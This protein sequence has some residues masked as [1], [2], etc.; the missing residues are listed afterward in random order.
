[1]EH[2]VTYLG[3]IP[4]MPLIG[5]VVIGLM[6]LATCKGN[7]LPEKLYGILACVG[8]VLSF[9]LAVKVFFSLKGMPEEARYLTHKA[10]TWFHVGEMDISMGF[11]ADPLSSLM[12]LFVTFIGT[13]IHVYSIGYMSEDKNYGKFFAYLNLFLGSMLILVLGDGPVVMF[14]GWEGVGL[15]SYLLISFW[16]EDTDNVLAGNKAFIVNRIGDLGFVLGMGFL[17]WAIGAGGFDYLSLR[18]NAHNLTPAIG[19]AVCLLLFVGATGKSAQI[20]LYVWLPDAMAGPTPVSALIHAATMVTAGVYMVARFSFIYAHVPV[21][22][23][24]VAWVGILTALLAAIFGM[25]QEDIK[26]ILA[27]STVSQLGYMFAAVGVA[28]YSAGIFHVFTHAFF[29]ALLFLGSGSVIIALHH[30]QNIW[31]M[32]GLREKMPITYKT[33]FIGAL[34]LAGA[35]LF[36]GFFS[37][38]EILFS[39]LATGHTGIWAVGVLVA[40]MTAYYTFRMI[41]VVF[42][43]E[44]RDKHA[45]DHAKEPSS[46]MTVPLIILAIGAVFA[47]FL[48]VPGS[49][50]VS[51]WLSPSLVEH[52]PHVSTWYTV[53]AMV[54]SIIAFIIGITIAYR[55]F[56]KGKGAEEPV[57]TGFAKFG[58]NLFYVDQLYHAVFV[59]PYK[60]IGAVIWKF[61]DPNV[62]DLHVKLS[63]LLYRRLSEAFKVFQVG[64]VRIY[65]IYMVIGLSVM[66]LLISQSMN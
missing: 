53:F 45:F 14:V 24:I 10:F 35:P 55:K 30:E 57:Y 22:G 27:Y 47:G 49:L 63:T 7:R 36:S 21:A 18:E 8:P 54:T 61:F 1:M 50:K 60:A 2:T 44:A 16:S 29:K 56:G 51:H 52:H 20:P 62:A 37:K 4:L 65:A 43:G 39:A 13:L 5:A 41:F 34:A 42:H 17:F 32:G 59:R 12:L 23:S 28:A 33:M 9:L 25:F 31:K 19:L 6:H 66:S 64:Y 11:L 58:Y 26:K 48:N 40:G 3:L 38:D 15:C 46:L